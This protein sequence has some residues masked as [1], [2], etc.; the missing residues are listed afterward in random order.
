[1]HS[2]NGGM[3]IDKTSK[4]YLDALDAE[5]VAME[6]ELENPPDPAAPRAPSAR[7][8]RPEE[9]QYF[10]KANTLSIL[11]RLHNIAT[12]N[13]YSRDENGTRYRQEVSP[14]VQLAAATSFL[15]RAMGKPQVNV[16]LTSGERPIIIDSALLAQPLIQAVIEAPQSP[17]IEPMGQ[18]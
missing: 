11:E 15:D 9:V 6:A 4:E 12:D 14:G 1:M 13:L 2:Y 7:R 8:K 17:S 10:L 16:D 5:S 3:I 18:E